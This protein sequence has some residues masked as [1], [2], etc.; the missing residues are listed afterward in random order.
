MPDIPSHLWPNSIQPYAL[1]KQNSLSAH[2]QTFP[3]P[4]CPPQL[5]SQGISETTPGSESPKGSRSYPKAGHV[6]GTARQGSVHPSPKPAM[7]LPSF[8]CG[9]SLCDWAPGA[10]W[11]I[12]AE[13]IPVRALPQAGVSG[14]APRGRKAGNQAL[15]GK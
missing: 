10:P 7:H 3:T 15:K 4:Y 12:I 14:K 13:G 5:T 1:N 6:Q 8:Y 11:K 9:C 2:T